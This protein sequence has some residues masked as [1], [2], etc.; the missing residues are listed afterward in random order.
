MALKASLSTPTLPHLP[1]QRL[2]QIAVEPQRAAGNILRKPGTGEHA[3]FALLDGNVERGGTKRANA[4]APCESHGGGEF[5][6]GV[7]GQHRPRG[8]PGHTTGG[9]M[10]GHGAARAAGAAQA[11]GAVGGE[12][13]VIDQALR[14]QPVGLGARRLPGDGDGVSGVAFG[15]ARP[16][17]DAVSSTRSS[18]AR[19][20]A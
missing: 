10:G 17:Q 14:H 4:P 3:Q 7:I 16:A 8:L 2:R 13:G 19:V 12:G 18:P 11:A 6:L 5:G 15:S 20:V 1:Q 9:E